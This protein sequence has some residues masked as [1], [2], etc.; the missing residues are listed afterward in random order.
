MALLTAM[1]PFADFRQVRQGLMAIT[2]P[3][4]GSMVEDAAR[5]GF[6]LDKLTGGEVERGF[7]P[8][9]F[10]AIQSDF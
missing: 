8:D 1:H 6:L 7:E 10:V 4:M 2:P 9:M 3:P 5:D